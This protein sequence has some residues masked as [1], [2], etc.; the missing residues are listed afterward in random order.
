MPR[1]H[2]ARQVPLQSVTDPA[3][4]KKAAVLGGQLGME[5]TGRMPSPSW[6]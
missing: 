3:G 5:A 2:G 4:G 6:P 1:D